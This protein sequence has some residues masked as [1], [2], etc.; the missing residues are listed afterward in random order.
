M[1]SYIDKVHEYFDSIARVHGMRCTIESDGIVRYENETVSL[2]VNYDAHRSHEVS[3]CLARKPLSGVPENEYDLAEILRSQ[4][5]PDAIYVSTL[6]A[7][8][9]SAL[10]HAL[11]RLAS[12]VGVPRNL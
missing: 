6:M 11:H 3:V 1:P 4:N 12:L 9:S 5:S 7:D 8:N 10:S 2:K